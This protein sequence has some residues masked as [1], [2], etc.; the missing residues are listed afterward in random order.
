MNV[1]GI[2]PFTKLATNIA[3]VTRDLDMLALNVIIEIGG[4][5]HVTADSTLPLSTS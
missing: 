2:S 4:L 3:R 5:G 1:I